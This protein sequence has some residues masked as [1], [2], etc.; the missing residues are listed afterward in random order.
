MPLFPFVLTRADPACVSMPVAVVRVG[1]GAV[2]KNN[3]SRGPGAGR[4][5]DITGKRG[6]RTMIEAETRQRWDGMYPQ[7]ECSG[8]GKLLNAD[9]GH[10]AELYAGTYTGLCYECEAHQQR[11]Q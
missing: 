2:N 8:C 1:A 10:P 4:A 11:Y 6:K 7:H 5:L 3:T 9:G